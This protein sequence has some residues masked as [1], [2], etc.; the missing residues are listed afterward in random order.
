MYKVTIL[1]I[2][3]YYQSFSQTNSKIKKHLFN[4]K[5][6]IIEKIEGFKF[7]S[8]SDVKNI[9]KSKLLQTSNLNPN[10]GFKTIELLVP[11]NF[12][13]YP[14]IHLY[15][16]DA[17]DGVQATIS[18]FIEYKNYLKTLYKYD[19]N[20][21]IKEV[22]KDSTLIREGNKQNQNLLLHSILKDN[23]NE[24]STLNIIEASSG[25]ET[26][27]LITLSQYLFVNQS[28]IIINYNML[29]KNFNDFNLIL[30]VA[31]QF[32]NL[33]NKNNLNEIN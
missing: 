12:N 27:K 18:D 8:E 29:Y 3:M 5:Q 4:D 24:F 31:N 30:R 1:L 10:V 25:K 14:L 26:T 28:I 32:L 20:I 23:N 2:L 16:F 6:F 11:D 22:L 13:K 17:L 21:A 19:Y 15:S 9:P 33:F 7:H